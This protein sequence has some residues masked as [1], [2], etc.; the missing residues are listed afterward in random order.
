MLGIWIFSAF[1]GG[2]G[3]PGIGGGGGFE[4]GEGKDSGGE[5]LVQAM[6]LN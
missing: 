5:T 2:C 3:F 6:M 1:R 4:M